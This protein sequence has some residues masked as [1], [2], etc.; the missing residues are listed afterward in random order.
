MKLNEFFPKG[1]G[2]FFAWARVFFAPWPLAQYEKRGGDLVVTGFLLIFAW[3]IDV[4][5]KDYKTIEQ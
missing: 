4:T 2:I 1:A 3:T 5:D